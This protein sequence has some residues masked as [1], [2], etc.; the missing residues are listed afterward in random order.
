MG[1]DDPP[2]K[3]V[4]MRLVELAEA[5]GDVPEDGS[6]IDGVWTAEIPDVDGEFD[7][8]IAINAE[9]EELEY[10]NGHRTLEIGAFQ[11]HA[12]ND[13]EVIAPAAILHPTGGS[14]LVGNDFE[15]SVEDQLIASVEAELVELGEL[16]DPVVY[17]GEEVT[18]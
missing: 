3:L 16:D 9:D 6:G 13:P 1:D 12:W 14:Q 8:F 18:A 2:I 7:W 4:F 15:R 10:N 5:R 11:G 17:D